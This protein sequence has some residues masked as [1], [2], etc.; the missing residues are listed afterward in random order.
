M[1]IDFQGGRSGIRGSLQGKG[2]HIQHDEI[3]RIMNIVYTS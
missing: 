2:H 1:M 3:P